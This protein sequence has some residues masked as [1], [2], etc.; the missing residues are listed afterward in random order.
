MNVC[1]P[2]AL[3]LCAFFVMA[4]AAFGQDATDDQTEKGQDMTVRPQTFLESL[5]GSWEGTCRTWFRPGEL[6][7][8]SNMTGEFQLILGGRVLRHT[9]EGELQGKPRTGEETIAFN[10]VKEKFEISWFDD[11]HMSDGILFSVGEPTESGFSVFGEYAVGAGQPNWGWRTVFELIDTN[12]LT[13]TA[14]N[15]MPDGTEAKAVKTKYV[16]N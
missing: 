3:A 14:Y 13:I 1:K 12:H 2:L 4:I 16:R 11:F 10:S 5:V 6:A 15:V 7:D 9:Y 8:E